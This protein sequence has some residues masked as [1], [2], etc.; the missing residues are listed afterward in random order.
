MEWDA[1]PL[2]IWWTILLEIYVPTSHTS[3]TF[4]GHPTPYT[5]IRPI[6]LQHKFHNWEIPNALKKCLLLQ[7]ITHNLV[8][9]GQKARWW[10]LYK[11]F[12]LILMLNLQ[13]F[14]YFYLMDN[15]RGILQCFDFL[16]L[17]KFS[18]STYHCSL[19]NQYTCKWVPTT[20]IAKQKSSLGLDHT[21]TCLHIGSMII[22]VLRA[23]CIIIFVVAW[24]MNAR[25]TP[26]Q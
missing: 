7:A 22:N 3:I 19:D 23:C 26:K 16:K 14:T 10:F 2:C 4:M 17:L 11:Q 6:F 1:S 18:A 20:L 8:L 12:D 9:F 25:I 5:L 13:Y 24:M 15:L 21:N